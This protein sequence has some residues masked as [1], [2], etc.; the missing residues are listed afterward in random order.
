MSFSDGGIVGEET[1]SF[2]TC[3]GS[4]SLHKVQEEA[5]VVLVDLSMTRGVAKS[6][7]GRHGSAGVPNVLL[8]PDCSRFTCHSL[9]SALF[10]ARKR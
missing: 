2:F 8:Y 4:K 5:G 6:V 1:A 7:D 10:R 3:E 9:D